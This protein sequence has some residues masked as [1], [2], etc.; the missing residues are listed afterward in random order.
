MSMSEPNDWQALE[1]IPAYLYWL[2]GKGRTRPDEPL[3]AVQLLDPVT[4][5]VVAEAEAERLRFAIEIAVEAVLAKD[6][7]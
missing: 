6:N 1:K 5:A 2:I 7:T 3:Y 4:H